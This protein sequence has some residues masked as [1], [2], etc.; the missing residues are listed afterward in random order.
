MA[1]E[2]KAP[3]SSEMDKRGGLD[4]WIPSEDPQEGRFVDHDDDCDCPYCCE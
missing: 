1:K 2:M 3:M 4:G